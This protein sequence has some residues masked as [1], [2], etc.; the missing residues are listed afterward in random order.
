M[1]GEVA[2]LLA[3]VAE[4]RRRVAGTQFAGVIT[5]VKG[6]RVRVEWGRDYQGRPVLSPWLETQNHR[7]GARERRFYQVGQNVTIS[8]VDGQLDEAA[9]IAADAPNEKFPAPDQADEAGEES[10]TYQLGKLYV[11]KKSESYEIYFKD[12]PVKLLL[13]EDGNIE[14]KAKTK[15]LIET[16]LVEMTKD[17]RVKG[18]VE[19]DGYV[20]AGGEVR[21]RNRVNLSTHTHG[22]VERGDGNTNPPN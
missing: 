7:G 12:R 21:A 16:P 19:V 9:T 18:N 2:M 11:T 5:E 8:T 14:I 13:R 10:E 6:D 20:Y 15:V 4:L 1:A 17:L 3:E 22:G